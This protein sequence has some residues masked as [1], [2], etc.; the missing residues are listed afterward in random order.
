MGIPIQTNAN[1]SVMFEMLSS[2]R[3]FHDENVVRQIRST[4]Q[5]PTAEYFMD[6]T[7]QVVFDDE[8]WLIFKNNMAK[9]AKQRK[10]ENA[11]AKTPI[12]KVPVRSNRDVSFDRIQ[13][14]STK[15]IVRICK[16]S[17]EITKYA[18]F[19]EIKKTYNKIE[20]DEIY[21]ILTGECDSSG[22]FWTQP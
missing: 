9:Q 20:S 14:D 4:F 13:L 17:F 8:A 21:N 2:G 10:K 7:P 1:M 19:D 15:K 5:A 16:S 12:N 22:Y 11:T 3:S 6:A 18:N